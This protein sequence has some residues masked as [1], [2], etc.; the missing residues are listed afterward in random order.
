MKIFLLFVLS[1]TIAVG[2]V[3]GINLGLLH[4]GVTLSPFSQFIIG[5]IGGYVVTDIILTY[6]DRR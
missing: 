5:L 1:M 3:Y 4:L 6:N 2:I